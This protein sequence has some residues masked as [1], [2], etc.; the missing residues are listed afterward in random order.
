MN[1][2]DDERAGLREELAGQVS[3]HL[4]ALR[5]ALRRLEAPGDGSAAGA[6]AL[7][8][9]R[10]EARAVRGTAALLG[11][12]AL[13]ETAACLERAAGGEVG[14]E[15]GGGARV[16]EAA[17]T[18]AA[19]LEA[20]RPSGAGAAPVGAEEGVPLV[21]HVEDSP[22]NRR[23]LAAVLAHR[24]EVGLLEAGS[25]EEGLRLAR[26]PGVALVLLDLRLP[27]LAG[28]EVLEALKGD[29]ATSHLRVVVVS[30]EARVGER[31]RLFAAGA[32][33]Y[34]VKPYDVERL[35]ATVD[36]AL[37]RRRP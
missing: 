19:A 18:L 2:T 14:G 36:E 24:P 3:L 13:A 34:I 1:L 21:L 32:D 9:L 23:L 29:P 20:E 31:D 17:R 5:D 7:A 30:A 22:A 4:A 11:L 10:H 35:L 27:G 25:G 28:E 6:E 16:S 33:D 15:V 12:T 8:A 37:V 26:T